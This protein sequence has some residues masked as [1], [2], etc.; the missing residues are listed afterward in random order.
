MD[1]KAICKRLLDAETEAE[2][3][4]IIENTPELREQ[5][6][7]KPLD[8]RE[9]NFNVT[10]N[11]ASDG[12]KAL[13]ELMTNMVDA[14]LTKQALIQG[15]DPRG[16]DAPNTMYEAVEILCGK[17]LYGGRLVNLDRNDPW[18]R[19]FSQKNLIIGITGARTKSEGLPS[20]TFVDNGEGQRA[21]DFEKTFLSLS[22]GNKKDIPFVQG[23]FN[24]GSS[25]VLGYCGHKWFKLIVSR[26]YDRK[27]HWAWTLVR[28]R[29]D[30]GE[31]MPIAEYF[32]LP[33]E[34]IPEF[35]AERLYPFRTMLKKQYDG[36]MLESG[37]I[38]KLFDY[39]IGAAHLSFRGAREALNENLVETILPFRLL[40]FRQLPR[41]ERARKEAE[42]RG[43]DRAMGIDSRP[44]Y[45][46]EFLLLHSHKEED[47]QDEEEAAG[48]EGI[49]V[50]KIRDNE[51]GDIS[52]RAIQ[53]RRDLPAWL[54]KTKNRVFHAVNGQVQF[55]QTRGFMSQT[56]GFPALKDRVIIIVDS[57][58]LKFGAHNNIW[59]GDREHI[60]KTITGERYNALVSKAIK[61]S[62]ALKAL[63]N[64][65]SQEELKRA[66]KTESNEIF[67]RLVDADRNLAGLLSN[68]H[69]SIRLPMLGGEDGDKGDDEFEGQFSPTFLRFERQS[70]RK[71]IDFSIDRSR[72]IVAKTDVV[73]GYFDRADNT[74]SVILDDS[75]K[76]KFAVREHLNNGRLVLYLEPNLEKLE[77]GNELPFKIGLYDD[78]MPRPV[79]T[80]TVTLRI[81]E[82]ENIRR[83]PRPVPPDP[84]ME[85]GEAPV[86]GLPKC[87]LLTKDGRE[88]PNYACQIWPRGFSAHDGG[89]VEDAPTESGMEKI[90]KINYDNIYHIKYRSEQRNNIAKEALTA[91]YIL[92]MRILMLGYEHSLGEWKKASNNKDAS[93]FD[94]EDD[95]RR[96]AARGAAS[97]VIAL[98]ES[99]PKFVDQS[100]V[101][102]E[103]DE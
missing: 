96:M 80:E 7:W 51:I 76:E 74:G 48:E 25:G 85:G 29:P 9:T 35:R 14:V 70:N 23:K 87:I 1:S 34:S 64:Q 79:E 63:Q 71:G 37:T 100:T 68:L 27:S 31:N 99:L 86:V 19:E 10:S 33:G 92:G 81:V 26:R 32:T 55:K 43:G 67:Q 8:G 18:L 12:G 78:S 91:K 6:N 16:P 97:T 65:I 58:N 73:N 88:I 2:I 49:S 40:D 66:T 72:P 22:D 90:Y 5:S 46:M 95:F 62:D 98:A 69:P 93:E 15:I 102:Q 84:P 50:G 54:S 52:I 24:M 77:I 21:Y 17:R 36:V 39:Q 28:R 3:Q 101:Q 75:I 103:V 42:K 38:V 94:F 4:Y 57:S 30:E 83:K 20:Y 13:T 11:Q 59:K 61:E 56:C 45:G 89:L 41:G 44:F 60:R 47:S 53:L 82:K